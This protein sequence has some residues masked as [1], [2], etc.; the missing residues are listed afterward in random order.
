MI[1]LS[2][3][4]KEA[5]KTGLAMTIALGL[6]LGLGWMHPYWAG[7]AVAMISLPTAG[8]SLI[9]GVNRILGTIVGCIA[10]MVF[11]GLF[12]QQRFAFIGVISVYIAVCTWMLTGKRHQYFWNVAG[13]VCL[14]I[15]LVGPGAEKIFDRAVDRT[16]ATALGIA[17]YT[18]VSVFLW[19]QTSAKILHGTAA[20][21]VHTHAQLFGIYKGLRIG[22]EAEF[23]ELV[24]PSSL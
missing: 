4:A 24:F 6:V 8:Q 21:L 12:P 17:V 1:T 22:K 14:I 23:F 7:F 16:L 13:F 3:R 11:L 10:A 2:T 18:G 9:K 5:I 15:C 19:P 20:K